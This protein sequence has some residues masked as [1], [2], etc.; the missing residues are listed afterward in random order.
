MT[1]EFVVEGNVEAYFDDPKLYKEFVEGQKRLQEW[2]REQFEIAASNPF[3]LPTIHMYS[4]T[5]NTSE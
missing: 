4:E 5:V 3:Y 2:I 1:E